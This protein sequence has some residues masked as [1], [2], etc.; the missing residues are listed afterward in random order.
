MPDAAVRFCGEVVEAGLDPKAGAFEAWE[1]DDFPCGFF[2]GFHSEPTGM[3]SAQ[4]CIQILPIG[5]S[6]L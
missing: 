6:V 2:I 3:L 4:N 1:I 5:K